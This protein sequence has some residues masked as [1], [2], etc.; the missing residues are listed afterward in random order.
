MPK[1]KLSSPKNP[2]PKRQKVNSKS[3]IVPFSSEY[4]F[5]CLTNLD[6]TSNFICKDSVPIVVFQ[7]ISQFSNGE[8]RGC[9]Y[10]KQ[11]KSI[12]LQPFC[13]NYDPDAKIK[14]LMDGYF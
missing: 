13:V 9:K 8:T 6:K 2:P 12:N 5:N 4:Y 7:L 1:R 11:C 3:K 10:G 14:Y